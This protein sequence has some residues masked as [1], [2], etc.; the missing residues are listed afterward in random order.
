MTFLTSQGRQN[1]DVVDMSTLQIWVHPV[2]CLADRQVPQVRG[3]V[4]KKLIDE[5]RVPTSGP[6][7]RLPLGQE[8]PLLYLCSSRIISVIVKTK[9]L[10]CFY[11]V[12]IIIG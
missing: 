3:G 5:D 6:A 8:V 11:W 2:H 7:S 10:S 12:E 1:G 4:S 9:D